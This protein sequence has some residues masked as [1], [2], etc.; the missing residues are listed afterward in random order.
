MEYLLRTLARRIGLGK[1]ADLKLV[2]ERM[3][4]EY[5]RTNY[6]VQVKLKYKF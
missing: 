3:Q 2:G 4:D 1:N 5:S 6:Q